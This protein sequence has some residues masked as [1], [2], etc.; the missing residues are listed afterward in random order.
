ML[1]ESLDTCFDSVDENGEPAVL[2]GRFTLHNFLQFMSGYNPEL[3]VPSGS[4]GMIF[5]YLNPQYC[6]GDVIRSLINEVRALREEL[7]R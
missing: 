3:T 6:E 4:T 5:E 7:G 2:G 1:E